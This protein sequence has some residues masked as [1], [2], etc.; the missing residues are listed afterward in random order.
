MIEPYLAFAIQSKTYGCT[1]REDIKKNLHNLIPQIEGCLYMGDVLYPTKLVVLSE[2]A[3]Q[4]FYDEHSRMD[5][6]EACKK[7]AITLPG[8]ESERLAEIAKKWKVYLVA[9]AK[10]LEPD[11]IKDRFFNTAFIIDPEGNIIHKHR[12]GRVF[13][14]ESTTTPCDIHDIWKEKVGEGLDAFYPVADT[15]IGR[16]GTMICYEGYFC[17]TG[18]L[19][20]LNGA[21]VLCRGGELEHHCNIGVWEVMNRAHAVNN[22]CYMVAANSGPKFHTTSESVPSMTGSTGSDT[23]IC[24]Y[25]GQ[26]M[27]RVDKPHISYA[28]AVINIEELR[29]FR[30]KGM[31]SLLPHVPAE[32]WGELYLEAA[33]KFSWPKNLYAEEAPPL[34]PE[35]KKFYKDIVDQM[36]RKGLLSPPE[37]FELHERIE[38]YEEPQKGEGQQKEEELVKN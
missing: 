13:T 12:K 18:R 32:L 21:E 31:I 17:E 25:R 14:P 26:I 23:M 16:I 8:E 11:I 19:L 28:A 35:R 33:K 37:G 6:V 36:I 10:V 15:P 34:Y 3:L 24:N 7:I 4:G 1:S 38:E 20:A 27:S 22:S 2:G 29:T 5:H 9:Q 30:V